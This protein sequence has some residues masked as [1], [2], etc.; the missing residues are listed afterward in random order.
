MA[1]RLSTQAGILAA[2]RAAGQIANALV[3]IVV[4]RFLAREDFGTFRQIYLLFATF[5][6]LADFGFCESLYYFLPRQ[7]EKRALFL[8]RAF[9]AVG[10]LQV[11]LAAALV[12][13]RA[14]LGAFFNN[15]ALPEHVAMLAA[16]SGF[17][18]ISR[19]WEYQL[20]AQQRIMPAALVSGGYEILKVA[21]MFVSLAISP[22]VRGL[23]LALALGSGLKF[24]AF[25]VFLGSEY[26]WFAGVRADAATPAAEQVH[27]ALA[28]GLPALLN[29]GAIQAHQY[30]VGYF[31]SPAEYALYSV[32]CFQVPLVGVLTTSIIEVLLVR[33]TAANAAGRYEEVRS[34]W[35]Q[36]CTKSLLIFL[37]IAAGLAA[38]SV[39]LIST[40]FTREYAAAAPLFAI[41]IGILPL[42]A[43]FTDNVL[44]AH[45]AMKSYTA[46]YAAR[47]ALVLA[48]GIVGVQ[49]FGL[50]GAAASSVAALAIIKVWQLRKVS[51]LLRV[52]YADVLPWGTLARIG[53][54][55]L[56][57]ALPAY[58]LARLHLRPW[59]GLTAGIALYAGVYVTIALLL[60]LATWREILRAAV[61]LVAAVLPA[62]DKK[63]AAPAEAV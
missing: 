37:P 19:L 22:S 11:A 36:A 35:N 58:E 59:L 5:I 53:L 63:K 24:L 30:I 25:L 14:P 44:R 45:G 62:R 12:A 1:P 28:L 6:V 47:M 26:R 50:W 29:V 13:L 42:N 2:S 15:T 46:F 16:A 20:I 21:L 56:A 8:R 18:V 41:L 17:T 51:E 57:A 31:S 38:L 61:D 7:P 9:L 40:L 10:A 60:R 55:A 43:L 49:Q 39:P 54:A 3:G 23:L 48:L 52:P 32:A 33:I 34:L 27:Y 4:V